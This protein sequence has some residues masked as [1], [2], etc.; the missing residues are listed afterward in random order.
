VQTFHEP[1]SL[2]PRCS[3]L[4][5][6][7]HPRAGTKLHRARNPRLGRVYRKTHSKRGRILS[8]EPLMPTAH[9]LSFPTCLSH[10]RSIHLHCR[11]DSLS[12]ANLPCLGLQQQTGP[13]SLSSEAATGPLPGTLSFLH[14]LS[15]PERVAHRPV[16]L[17]IPLQL[18]LS[19]GE[20]VAHRS[21]THD[22]EN[23]QKPQGF[24]EDN[25]PTI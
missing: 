8:Q 7:G 11:L 2:R 20:G 15:H 21:H 6:V 4:S 23:T 18:P 16:P 19:P 17:F 1:P 5:A 9:R 14:A 24:P 12:A 10:P 25:N 22:I 13:K 3:S